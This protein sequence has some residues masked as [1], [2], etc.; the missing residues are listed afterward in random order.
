MPDKTS[1]IHFLECKWD[2]PF[3]RYEIKGVPQEANGTLA[4]LT[5]CVRSLAKGEKMTLESRDHYDIDE[6]WDWHGLQ[7]GWFDFD[8]E[9]TGRNI[10]IT[11]RTHDD[12]RALDKVEIFLE[13][14]GKK[15][16]VSCEPE[17]AVLT[18]PVRKIKNGSFTL[19][20]KFTD[21]DDPEEGDPSVLWWRLPSAPGQFR[22]S[23]GDSHPQRGLSL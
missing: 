2:F 10:V 11:V 16:A 12:I 15:Y 23:P 6:S 13:S 17:T 21:N 9:Y 5:D 3:A 7:D 19:N 4:V 14:G 22:I 18:V 20:V 1:L 8:V